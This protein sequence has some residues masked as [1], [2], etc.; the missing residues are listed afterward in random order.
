[1]LDHLAPNTLLRNLR[2]SSAD[3][4][5]F[6]TGNDRWNARPAKEQVQK[7]D[8][9]LSEIELVYTKPAKRNSEQRHNLTALGRLCRC[10]PDAAGGIYLIFLVDFGSTV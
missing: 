3:T 8:P 4:P 5:P 1:M 6:N 7:P 10:L 9:T 2:H